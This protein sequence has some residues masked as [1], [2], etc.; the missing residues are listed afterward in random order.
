M[1]QVGDYGGKDKEERDV[2]PERDETI[3][4]DFESATRIGSKKASEE[5][6]NLED[7]A[8]NLII[9]EKSNV[10]IGCQSFAK[11]VLSMKE[12]QLSG[13]SAG[14]SLGE[15]DKSYCSIRA[16]EDVSNMGFKLA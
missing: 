6:K 14:I 9:L 10:N 12:E 3:V 5:R 2:V 16:L 1:S 4:S 15:V 13:Y 11:N 7:E 8:I